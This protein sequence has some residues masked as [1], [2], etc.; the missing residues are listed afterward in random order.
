MAKYTT[1]LA[2]DSTGKYVCNIHKAREYWCWFASLVAY[3][4]WGSGTLTWY[5]SPNNGTTLIPIKDLTDTAV[6]Q[7]ADGGV[8]VQFGVANKL[9]GTSDEPQIWVKLTGSTNPSLT[10]AVYDNLS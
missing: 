5:F 10:I 6:S 2:A 4:T 8:N 3:G 9:T 7:T 1:T